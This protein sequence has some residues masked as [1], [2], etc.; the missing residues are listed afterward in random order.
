MATLPTKVLVAV[1]AG[2]ASEHGLDS[3]RE[4][5]AATGAELHLVHVQLTRASV[6]GRPMTPAQRAAAER[7]G[8]ALLARLRARVEDAGGTVA[9][10][11]LRFGES[12]ERAL[13]DAQRELDDA[14]LVI[15]ARRSARLVRRLASSGSPVAPSAV[16][17]RARGP[18]L[19]V[20]EP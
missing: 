19:V 18:V 2:S 15:P 17:R 6:R 16:V 4:L 14:L 5:C 1:D 11:H 9:D 20:R 8:T 12:V 10:T 13:V 3:A 7:D